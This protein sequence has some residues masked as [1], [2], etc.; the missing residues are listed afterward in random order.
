[1]KTPPACKSWR[2]TLYTSEPKK[3][4]A[5]R[6]VRVIRVFKANGGDGGGR[7]F[8]ALRFVFTIL[9]PHFPRI[10]WRRILYIRGVLLAADAAMQRLAFIGHKLAICVW[11]CLKFTQSWLAQFGRHWAGSSSGPNLVAAS[12]FIKFGTGRG[13]GP[14]QASEESESGVQEPRLEVNCHAKF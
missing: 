8:P 7:Q 11:P 1:M 9:F 5:S 3:K 14:D 4:V 2:K 10:L 12:C 6:E 13:R